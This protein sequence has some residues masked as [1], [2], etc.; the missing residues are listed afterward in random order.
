M[1]FN[2]GFKGLKHSVIQ[3]FLPFIL[4]RAV[5]VYSSLILLFFQSS[6][7]LLSASRISFHSLSSVRFTFSVA[8]S[9]FTISF[10]YL[11]CAKRSVQVQGLV[12]CFV[13]W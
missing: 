2:S 5:L 12:K 11:D 9:Y 10:N 1:G 7:F 4:Q 6:L 13:K 8:L 3:M